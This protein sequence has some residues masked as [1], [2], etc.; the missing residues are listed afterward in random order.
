M[1]VNPTALMNGSTTVIKHASHRKSPWYMQ[2]SYKGPPKGISDPENV[3][4]ISAEIR[5]PP[6]F[7][8]NIDGCNTGI[9]VTPGQWHQVTVYW[10]KKILTLFIDGNLCSIA[11]QRTLLITATADQ[12]FGARR[13]PFVFIDNHEVQ[14]FVFNDADLLPTFFRFAQLANS[15]GRLVVTPIN[16]QDDFYSVFRLDK[17]KPFAS[18]RL[19]GVNVT[20]LGVDGRLAVDSRQ[21][22]CNVFQLPMSCIISDSCSVEVERQ[23]LKIVVHSQNLLLNTEADSNLCNVVRQQTSQTGLVPNSQILLFNRGRSEL[24]RRHLIRIGKSKIATIHF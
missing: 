14:D 16:N 15:H 6:Y 10:D 5:A 7:T 21:Q 17:S 18:V 13:T 11:S 8:W 22:E 23:S 24:L 19:P 9:R 12:R 4:K 1:F 2:I 20:I 3:M